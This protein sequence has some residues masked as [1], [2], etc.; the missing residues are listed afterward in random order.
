MDMLEHLDEDAIAIHELGPPEVTEKCPK[1]GSAVDTTVAYPAIR[2][3]PLEFGKLRTIYSE[4]APQW[5]NRR[6]SF[7]SDIHGFLNKQGE[8]S[9]RLLERT[10][11]GADGP[12]WFRQRLFYRSCTAFYR[13]LQLFFAYLVME[14]N[15]FVTW[16]EVT[17]Y[18]SRFYFIQ[19]F[20]NLL[21]ST[22][23]ERERIFIFHDGAGIRCVPQRKLSPTLKNAHSHEVWWQLMEAIK[24]PKD[25]PPENLS[26]VLSRFYFNPQER[27]RKN[28]DFRYLQGF[29]ELDWFDTSVEQFM[30]HFAHSPRE[31]RD[32]TDIDRFFSG[33]DPEY[34]DVS[35]F[36]ADDAQIIWCSLKAYMETLVSLEFN[37]D[38]IKTE[39]IA[40]LAK[41]HLS[42]QYPVMLEGIVLSTSEL[43]R[44]NFDVY[45]FMKNL[46]SR[47]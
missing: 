29:I 21:Q 6:E 38:F 3:F 5:E 25:Y 41:V 35:D 37:Q 24:H 45:A 44:D 31:D 46:K 9:T 20:L 33:Y 39:K 27:N 23:T 1:C 4:F 32:I 14:H 16:A 13:S 47:D 30:S 17:G 26:F 11:N 43:L 12:Q 2:D 22:W 8:D 7:E 15:G 19:A 36:Y 10:L 18:Y 40:A 42:S 34:C 28:Y